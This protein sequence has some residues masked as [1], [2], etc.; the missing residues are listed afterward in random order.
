METST[1]RAMEDLIAVALALHERKGSLTNTEWRTYLWA[2]CSLSVLFSIRA[3]APADRAETSKLQI[4]RSV[5][6]SDAFST[7]AVALAVRFHRGRW[8]ASGAV[9]APRGTRSL[10]IGS[11]EDGGLDAKRTRPLH[12]LEEGEELQ[13]MPELEVPAQQA[14]GY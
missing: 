14:V 3:D 10:Q 13:E 8:K 7:D 1:D 12:A 4:H 5:P 6:K 2:R 11:Q 9:S